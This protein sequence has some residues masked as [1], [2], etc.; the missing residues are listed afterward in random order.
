VGRNRKPTAELERKDAFKHDP[1]RGRARAAEPVPEGKLGPPPESFGPPQS[2]T[3]AELRKIWDELA[4]EAKEVLL[5]SA[6]RTHFEMTVRL[7]W[8]CRRPGAK[9]G[10]FAQLNRYLGQLGLNPVDRSKVI[11]VHG[12][13]ADDEEDEWEELESGGSGVR[14]Q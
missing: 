8:R 7:K 2:Q 6:D 10:D 9:T 4:D 14:L 11:S 13:S 12:K 5:T 3:G 1:A